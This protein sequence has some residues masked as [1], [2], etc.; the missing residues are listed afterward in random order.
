MLDCDVFFGCDGAEAPRRLAGIQC[1]HGGAVAGPAAE[2]HSTHQS[3]WQAIE[4]C[5][6]RPDVDD[7]SCRNG[8]RD[9]APALVR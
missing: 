4:S 1:W 2:L 8:L 5:R 9:T 3:I 7:L 6:G